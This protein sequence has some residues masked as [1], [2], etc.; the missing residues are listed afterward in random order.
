MKAHWLHQS[1]RIVWCQQ[2][3]TQILRIGACETFHTSINRPNLFYSVRDKPATASEAM[4]DLMAWIRQ[5]SAGE[6][7][8]A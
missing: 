1:S 8:P 4:A 6:T 7:Y 3:L 2:D 5:H